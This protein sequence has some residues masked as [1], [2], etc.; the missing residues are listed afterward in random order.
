[1]STGLSELNVKN[2]NWKSE[3]YGLGY[4]EFE[5]EVKIN[6]QS[7][8][9]FRRFSEI[10][11]LHEMI[12]LTAAGSRLPQ[13]PEKN[14]WTN[15]GYH[16]DNLIKERKS[17]IDRYLNSI[18]AHKYLSSNKCFVKFIGQEFDKKSE[19]QNKRSF[20]GSFKSMIGYPSSSTTSNIKNNKY[21]KEEDKSNIQ[22]LANG[23]RE[24]VKAT[25]DYLKINMNKA[26]SLN[27]IKE[28]ST[29]IRKFVNTREDDEQS[30]KIFENNSDYLNKIEKEYRNCNDK[31]KSQVDQLKEYLIVV[32]DIEKIFIRL[33][34]Y[35]NKE[36]K[37]DLD[38]EE[39]SKYEKEFKEQLEY[40]LL[41]FKENDEEKL[42]DIISCIFEEKIEMNKGVKEILSY[43]ISNS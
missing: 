36:S 2:Y 23:V 41:Q 30:N 12:N 18:K 42:F 33:D 11:W 40:E 22:R 17:Q 29:S 5:I 20:F 34:K 6:T 9:I 10:E 37:T 24:I 27:K 31:L 32:E 13:L 16:A 25:D 8:T 3:S 38:Q 43:S 35:P 21:Y 19:I 39:L 14:M 7:Y 15:F 28:I 4:Y 26:N 1:M